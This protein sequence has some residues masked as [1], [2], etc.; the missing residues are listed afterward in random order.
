MGDLKREI[1]LSI[2]SSQLVRW[3]LDGNSNQAQ[4]HADE[5]AK[6]KPFYMRDIPKEQIIDVV[7]GTDMS[8]FNLKIGESL[9]GKNS[10]NLFG[11]LDIG[12]S[13][14]LRGNYTVLVILIHP[15]K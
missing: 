3:K 5:M 6:S 12:I 15:S 1:L 11:R 9:M 7:K 2:N 4:E 10:E 13:N 14:T 8:R